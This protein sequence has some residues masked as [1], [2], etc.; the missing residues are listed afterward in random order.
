MTQTPIAKSANSRSFQ[1]LL[2]YFQDLRNIDRLVP[3]TPPTL[4]AANDFGEK[5][6]SLP[7]SAFIYT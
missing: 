7:H 5:R 2:Q 4:R 1:S 3:L 6:R